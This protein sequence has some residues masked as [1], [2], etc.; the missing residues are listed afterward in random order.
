MWMET[1]LICKESGC[2]HK[3]S[4][5]NYAISRHVKKHNLEFNSYIRKYYKLIGDI[6]FKK[7]S[8]CNNEALPYF[9]INHE[10]LTYQILYEKGYQCNTLECK[11]QISLDILGIEYDKKKYEKIGS[12]SDYLSILYGISIE[13]SKKMKYDENKTDFFNCSLESF[14][15]KY[16]ESE[17][18]IRY[19]KRIEGIKNKK[20]KYTNNLIKCNLQGFIEKYGEK[21][22]KIKYKERCSKVAYTNTLDY[23]INRFGK[24]EGESRYKHK[25]SKHKVSKKSKLIGHL[26]NELTI[27]YITE[28]NIGRK[29]VDYYLPDYNIVI[30]YYGDYWHCNPKKYESTFLHPQINLTSEEIWL[31]DKNRLNIIMENT[32]S[33]IVVWED[34]NINTILLEK[35]LYDI[36]DIKTIIYI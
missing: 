4:N 20:Y 23:Y 26:L 11:K 28:E 31:K 8:F 21:I 15:K 29:S 25:N 27:N 2:G 6:S 16:G 7:C 13:D 14:S 22:G 34:S 33:V 10:N 30:E 5:K 24:E 3:M 36:K 19:N 17:G 32:N 12:R 35:T 9:I 18:R 1:H